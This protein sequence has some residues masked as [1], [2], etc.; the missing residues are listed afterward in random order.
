MLVGASGGVLGVGGVLRLRL[1][2]RWVE[3]GLK[4]KINLVVWSG[5]GASNM[6]S[7]NR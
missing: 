4:L 6:S 2:L 7:G 3:L 5:R 1:G